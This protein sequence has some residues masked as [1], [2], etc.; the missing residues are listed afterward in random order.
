MRRSQPKLRPRCCSKLIYDR[1]FF[2]TGNA[3]GAGFTGSIVL[4]AAGL[5]FRMRH[6]NKE[7]DRMHGPASDHEQL[8]VTDLGESHPNFRYLL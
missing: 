5:Y 2:V 1:P 7:K 4:L 3:I 6:L 8:D